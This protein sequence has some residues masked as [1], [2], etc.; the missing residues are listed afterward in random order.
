MYSK[1]AVLRTTTSIN[2]ACEDSFDASAKSFQKPAY[3][4]SHK[5]GNTILIMKYNLRKNYLNFLKD[6]PM[7]SV[8]FTVTIIIR[9]LEL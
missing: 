3:S 8:N 9:G 7:I 1:D 2:T 4:I 6:V 5:G